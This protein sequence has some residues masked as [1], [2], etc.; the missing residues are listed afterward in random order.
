MEARV[1]A[2]RV[3]PS[4]IFDTT[5]LSHFACA[6]RL[7]ALES[8][9]DPFRCI[10]PVEVRIEIRAGTAA[11]PA[12]ADVLTADWL[13]SV[14]LSETRELSAFAR[15]KTLLGGGSRENTGEAAVLAWAGVHGD[16]AIIDER[17]ASRI[18]Q[19]DGIMAH[20]SLWLVVQ[21]VRRGELRRS[22]A[23]QLVDELRATGMR[24]PTDGR[25]LFSWAHEQGLLPQW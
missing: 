6:G 25:S 7:P 3:S 19:R 10:A 23:E 20:G 17:A 9:V 14:E 8:L 24:L 18:A 5:C 15:Y 21:G 12:L 13:E 22:A 16:V 1:R 2:A 4:L 11:I